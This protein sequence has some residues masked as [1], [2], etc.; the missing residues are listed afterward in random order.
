MVWVINVRALRQFPI[1]HSRP[2]VNAIIHAAP[3]HIHLRRCK[4]D[5]G[6]CRHRVACCL[7]GM[8]SCDAGYSP[9]LHFQL[10]CGCSAG[11]PSARAWNPPSKAIRAS[12]CHGH[13]RLSRSTTTT[14]H[15]SA[16]SGC[17]EAHRCQMRPMASC[18]S[19]RRSSATAARISGTCAQMRAS[20][21]TIPCPVYDRACQPQLTC[22][23]LASLQKLRFAGKSCTSPAIALTRRPCTGWCLN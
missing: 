17:Q 20:S 22:L 19:F 15:P 1:Q 11:M 23:S 12:Y 3:E 21:A 9:P 7:R 18:I 4:L 8:A 6:L 2:D 13:G 10:H 5:I 14:D 16:G